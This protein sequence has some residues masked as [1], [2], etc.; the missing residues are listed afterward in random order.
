MVLA[1]A[2]SG[3][4]LVELP[5]VSPEDR[6]QLI[7][8]WCHQMLANNNFNSDRLWSVGSALQGM[9]ADEH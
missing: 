7:V 6:A 3:Y 1:Y 9:L 5:R 8:D 2:S 4:S